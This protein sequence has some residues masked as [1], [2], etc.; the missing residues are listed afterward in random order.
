MAIETYRTFYKADGVTEFLGV[1]TNSYV[2]IVDDTTVLKYPRTPDDK[3]ALAIL[4]LEARMIES[5]GPHK[6]IINLK[7]QTKDG[8][9]LERAHFGSIAQYLKNN[10][11]PLQQRLDWA[12]QATEAVAT[13][14]R[15]RVLHRDISV[16][17]LLLDAKLNVKLCDFQGRLLGPDGN[18]EEDGFSVENI[19]S[20]MP[21]ANLDLDHADWKTEIFALGSAFY[22]IM[23][24][25][26]PFPNLDPFNDEDEIVERFKSG[27][28]P[29]LEFPLMNRVVHK[30]WVGK[31]NS[32]D[33]VLRD[34]ESKD[35]CLVAPV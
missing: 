33:A 5:V 9:L 32:A 29:E 25:N 21:R 16:N 30:C 7:G 13:V 26:E 15:A 10:D 28:F 3:T 24:G 22:Y 4:R 8:L 14:H 2:G 12:R 34:L 1:G 23:E 35:E 11:P 18:V 17:N 20:F 27:Q 6:H 31:Y 19:K